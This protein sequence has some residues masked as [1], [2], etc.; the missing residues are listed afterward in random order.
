[1]AILDPKKRTWGHGDPRL[2]GYEPMSTSFLDSEV[3]DFDSK[4]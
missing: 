2:K 4:L 3:S 1:L